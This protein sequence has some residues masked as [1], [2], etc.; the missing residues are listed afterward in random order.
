MYPEIEEEGNKHL[1]YFTPHTLTKLLKNYGFEIKKYSVDYDY[2]KSSPKIER[3]Y[4]FDLLFCHLTGI[5]LSNAILI[6]AQKKQEI[7]NVNRD[8][9]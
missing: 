9:I 6:A 3:K 5:N 4:K 8:L 1:F 2:G 7:N